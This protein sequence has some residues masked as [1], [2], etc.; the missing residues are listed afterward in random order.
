MGLSHALTV[1]VDE[2][3]G[4]GTGGAGVVRV[5]TGAKSALSLDGSVIGGASI[6][7]KN[8]G[9]TDAVGRKGV[10]SG[11]NSVDSAVVVDVELA[12]GTGGRANSSAVGE[13]SVDALGTELSK[14]T[15]G[16]AAS[17]KENALT[18]GH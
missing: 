17:G 14:R 4:N 6:A 16:Q 7:V 8:V 18:S 1:A 2:L 9:E 5:G 13:V 3:S 15:D 10:A 11:F 12:G